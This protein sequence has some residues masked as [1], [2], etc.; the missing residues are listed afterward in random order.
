MSSRVRLVGREPALAA[1]TAVLRDAASG[2]G[3]FLMVSGEAGIGKTAVLAALID[4]AGADWTILRGICWAGTGT[5]PYWPWSQVLRATCLPLADLGEAGRIVQLPAG[6]DGVADVGT[7][8]NASVAADAE[9]RLSEAVAHCLSALAADQPTLVVLDDLQWA[10]AASL[11]LLGFLARALATS[12]VLLVG[13]YRDAEASGDLLDL[14]TSAQHL[15]LTGLGADQVGELVASIAGPESSQRLAAQVWERSGGNPFF[16]RELAR[17]VLA[18]GGPEPRSPIPASITETLRR[19]LARL[20]TDCVRLLSWAAVAGRALD[21]DLLV[22]VG[23]AGNEIEVLELLAEARRA[24]VVAGGRD[25]P[26]IAHDLY[27]ETILSSLS[28]ASRAEID[29]AIGHALQDR[30]GNSARVAAH[31]L[32]AGS[33]AQREAVKYSVLAAREATAR[34]GHEDACEH[35]RRALQVIES[36]GW[37]DG[38]SRPRRLDLLVELAEACARAGRTDQARNNYRTAAAGA[39]R[40]GD[41]LIVARAAVGMHSLGHRS[42]RRDSE[43]LELLDEAAAQLATAQREPALQSRVHAARARILRHGSI[44]VPDETVIDAARRAVDLA[45]AARDDHALAEARLA[46]H[47]SLW[48]PGTAVRRLPV[49]AAMLDAAASGADAD[50]VAQAHQ[51]RAAALLELGEP[52]GRDE[53]LTY[54]A[55]AGQLGHARGRWGA[56]TR[57]ATYAQLA[58]QA[59]ES[60]RLGEEALELG[61]AIGEPDALGCFYTSRWSLVALGIREPDGA[62]DPTDPLWPMFPLL[63]AWPLAVRGEL[64]AATA[65]LGDFSVLDIAV[66]TGL[67]GLAVAA[68]VFAA[69]GTAEQRTW[70]YDQLRPHA[71]THVVVGGCASYHAAVDHHLGAL[72]ASLG[73]FDTAGDHFRT[74]LAMHSRLGAAGWARLTEQALATLP[75]SP[76]PVNEFRRENGLWWLAYAGTHTQLPD[77][78]GLR[79]LAVLIGAQGNEVHVS[80]L[81]GPEFVRTGA[82]PVLDE[83]AKAQYKTR[84]SELSEQI[85]EAE[86]SGDAVRADELRAEHDVLVHEL[87]AAAGLGGRARR[88]GDPVERARKTVSARVR[89]ALSKL[90][91]A[92]PALADH[93]R[94][95]VQLGTVCCYAPEQHTTWRLK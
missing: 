14:S 30:P 83:T 71:G 89:D 15:P 27:R 4:Q 49:I 55:L 5:P 19:R 79:D 29:L 82:D 31:L 48:T 39:R 13:A 95:A 51:L 18:Q 74:A 44:A 60:A 64:D 32:A 69:M 16:A 37:T 1:A 72:A 75:T 38:P 2:S 76:V 45:V 47:D 70:T 6:A 53:L 90:E 78:K 35:Y 68:V 26:R 80:T 86:E 67:E 59:E 66:W 81:I 20:S 21:T 88:L 23:A 43:T 40:A 10:D 24:G 77:S 84:L 50:L 34:L 25:E 12:R 22:R 92:H 57:R 17:L 36:D 63:K 58:G 28:A 9:F 73:D 11:R 7:T 94:H 62:M 3:Q 42:G 54:I 87:A 61:L 41:E 85:E 52:S 8:M 93:L 56:L 46:L 65:A 33:Q 91:H